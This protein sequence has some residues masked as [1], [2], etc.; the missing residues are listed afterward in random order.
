MIVWVSIVPDSF[1]LADRL[2]LMSGPFEGYLELGARNILWIYNDPN[3]NNKYVEYQKSTYQYSKA[4]T[5]RTFSKP[6]LTLRKRQTIWAIEKYTCHA[7]ILGLAIVV[8]LT[9]TIQP[10]GISH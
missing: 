10:G 4:L 5:F 3:I 8:E 1:W 9:I 7:W 2:D 6:F